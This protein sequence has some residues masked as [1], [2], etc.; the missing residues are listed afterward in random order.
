MTIEL[1]VK[2]AGLKLK[3]PTILAS[4][5]LGVSGKLLKRVAESGAGAVTT[6]SIGKEP[7]KGHPNPTVLEFNSFVMNAVGL[8]NPGYQNFKEEVKIAKEGQVPVIASIFAG[9]PEEFAFLAKEMEDANADAIELNISCPNLKPGEKIGEV[10]GKNPDLS[11]DVVKAVKKVVNIPVITKLTPN[12]NDIKVIA[13]AV[14]RAGTDI[15]SAIN[16]LGPG[17]V[18]DVE[19]AKPVLANKFGGLSGPAIHPIAVKFVYDIYETVK[20]PIIG[21]GGVTNGKDAIEMMMAGA[22]AVGIGSAIYYRGID[23]FKK[24]CDEMTEF[25]ESHGYSDLEEIKGIAHRD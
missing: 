18:I 5:F 4:G 20:V 8:S 11:H 17:M 21:I 14:E 2:L 10:I 3:N 23:V 16:T 12:V 7:R 19:T 15:I 24:V 13:E 22:S 9:D 6:K 25:L 1:N